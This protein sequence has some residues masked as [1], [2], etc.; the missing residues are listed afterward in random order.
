MQKKRSLI[1]FVQVPWFEHWS[2]QLRWLQDNPRQ[3]LSHWHTP[4]LHV[5]WPEQSKGEHSASWTHKMV[6]T[7]LAQ[8]NFL[9]SVLKEKEKKSIIYIPDERPWIKT[10]EKSFSK[11]YFRYNVWPINKININH[12]QNVVKLVFNSHYWNKEIWQL[13]TYLRSVDPD[14]Q[15]QS[16]PVLREGDLLTNCLWCVQLIVWITKLTLNIRSVRNSHAKELVLILKIIGQCDL[17]H[18]LTSPIKTITPVWKIS[19]YIITSI[20]ARPVSTFK[21]TVIIYLL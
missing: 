17:K 21:T 13:T 5:P 7:F 19:T 3:L 12:I 6:D 14:F 2:W 10:L 9:L 15:F 1:P 18:I 16:S 11:I 8:L 4:S 20:T